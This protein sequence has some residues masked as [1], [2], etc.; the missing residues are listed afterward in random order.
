MAKRPP[1][2]PQPILNIRPPKPRPTGNRAVRTMFEGVSRPVPTLTRK[3]PPRAPR[4]PKGMTPAQIASL[5]PPGFKRQPILKL[6]PKGKVPPVAARPK[7]GTAATIPAHAKTPA[8]ASTPAVSASAHAKAQAARTAR[9]PM[10]VQQGPGP[11]PRPKPA[12]A[13]RTTTSTTSTTSST[14]D[15]TALINSILQPQY[16][17]IDQAVAREQET[18]RQ[19]LA[20][21]S[22]LTQSYLKSISDLP[23]NV[24]GD[25]G[26]MIDQTNRM[27]QASA[28]RL[29]A[30]SPNADVQSMLQSIGAPATQEQQVATQAQNIFQ[31]GGAVLGHVQGTIPGE[32]LARVGAAQTA[33]AHELPAVVAAR[34]TQGLHSL[35]YQFGQ[36]LAQLQDQRAQVAAQ[37]PKLTMDIRNQQMTDYYKQKALEAEMALLPYKTAQA[38]VNIAKG[39]ATITQGA[40]RIAISKGNLKVRQQTAKTAAQK[41]ALANDFRYAE[42]YGYNPTTGQPTL[43]AIKAAKAAKAKGSKPPTATQWKNWNNMADLFY[44]GAP[45]K[46]RADGTVI[47][48]RVDFVPYYPALKRLMAS[49]A[50]LQ[51]AQKVLNAYYPKGG[52]R[53]PNGV[54]HPTGRPFVSLQGRVALGQA[55]MPLAHPMDAPSAQQK[56]YLQRHGLWSD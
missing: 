37:I 2:K 55:G 27:A 52:V 42:I 33:Y 5:N 47:T 3:T 49:G 12:A 41:A 43:A 29:A 10:W 51:Q 50:T 54:I 1:F 13:P 46:T 8:V 6:T 31:G 38:K 25:Y 30:A 28:D 11:K 56:A 23:A 4:G 16:Q 17:A 44:N 26:A 36:N 14:D 21:Y 40:Q 35:E 53:D 39:K 19:N 18:N 7:R 34:G 20:V 24:A 45:A 32:T 22:G 15:L 48:P 9:G